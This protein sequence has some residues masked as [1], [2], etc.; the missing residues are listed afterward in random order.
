MF[1][2]MSSDT[3]FSMKTKS[4]FQ[5][6]CQS[7]AT[8]KFRL[9]KTCKQI[10]DD[11]GLFQENYQEPLLSV[12]DQVHFVNYINHEFRARVAEKEN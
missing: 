12:I 6:K 3:K 9:N 7:M 10:A 4:I 1:S 5:I 11:W 8:N 2:S